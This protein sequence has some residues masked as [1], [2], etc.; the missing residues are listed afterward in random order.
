MTNRYK[1][2]SSDGPLSQ[3]GFRTVYLGQKERKA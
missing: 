2:L 3:P 1:W